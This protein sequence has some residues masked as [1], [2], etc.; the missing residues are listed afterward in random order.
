[1]KFLRLSAV[2]MTACIMLSS[3]DVFRAMLGKPTSKDLEILRLEQEAAIAQ[4]KYD[5]CAA[6]QAEAERIAAEQEAAAHTVSHRYYVALGGFKVPSN[7][8]NYKA[9]LESKGYE[10]TAVR[11]KSGYDV[12]LASGTDDLN[13]ALRSMGDFKRYE[14][15]C[16]YDVWIY[17][18][19]T[20][21]HE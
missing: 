18:T 12:I 9:Y 8:V 19:T 7:A 2:L 14:K 5:S 13:E 16:P 15:T 3:C 4:A 6:A 20:A 1:M 21:Y 17:D 10:I 11:F